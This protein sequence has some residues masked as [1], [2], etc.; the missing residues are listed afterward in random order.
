VKTVVYCFPYIYGVL[1][2]FPHYPQLVDKNI[3]NPFSLQSAK[4]DFRKQ[5][6]GARLLQT[7]PFCPLLFSF[8]N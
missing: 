2:P 7:P 5:K 6:E 4:A 3:H 1:F 8:F